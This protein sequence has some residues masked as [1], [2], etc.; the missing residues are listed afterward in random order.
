MVLSKDVFRFPRQ[1]GSRVVAY[2]PR[3]AWP[4]FLPERQNL[5]ESLEAVFLRTCVLGGIAA[6]LLLSI[7]GWV[8]LAMPAEY[9]LHY[10][11]QGLLV[12]ATIGLGLAI[13]SAHVYQ[14]RY[15]K[16]NEPE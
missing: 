10:A 6:S 4:A 14:D 9:P 16:S 2:V 15:P 7:T 5:S 12:T 3:P 8:A 13:I 11:A 1:M